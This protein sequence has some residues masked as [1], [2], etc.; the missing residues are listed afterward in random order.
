MRAWKA[1]TGL[2]EPVKA[3]PKRA[4]KPLTGL[5][6]IAAGPDLFFRGANGFL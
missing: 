1:A 3:R 2:T 5:D 6:R 4:A